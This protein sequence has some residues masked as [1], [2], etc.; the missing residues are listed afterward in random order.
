MAAFPAR[1]TA[2]NPTR[3]SFTGA[4]NG[5]AVTFHDTH[6]AVLIATNPTNPRDIVT[7]TYTL[8]RSSRTG[9]LGQRVRA[10]RTRVEDRI[11]DPHGTLP[12]PTPTRIPVSAAVAALNAPATPA[13]PVALTA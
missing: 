6:P 11:L 5:W 1:Y 8:Q 7:V 2:H 12:D 10:A 13:V 9:R 4:T 3:L